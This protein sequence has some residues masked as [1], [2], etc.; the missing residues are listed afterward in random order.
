MVITSPWNKHFTANSR[1]HQPCFIS[2]LNTSNRF[3]QNVI[4]RS[5]GTFRGQMFESNV[6]LPIMLQWRFFFLFRSYLCLKKLWKYLWYCDEHFDFF[7]EILKN[8]TVILSMS[9]SMVF[10][11]FA[12]INLLSSRICFTSFLVSVASA[13]PFSKTLV[14]VLTT[15]RNCCL[16]W[17]VIRLSSESG[18]TPIE[19]KNYSES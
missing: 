2:I 13:L 16:S 5:P 18:K 8:Q 7:Y 12:G 9:P 6:G 3:K 15:G 19:K 17:S 14:N 4:H 1:T 10:P 11:M